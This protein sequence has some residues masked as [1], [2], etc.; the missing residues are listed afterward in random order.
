VTSA[1]NPRLVVIGAGS[2]GVTVGAAIAWAGRADVAFATRG[3]SAELHLAVGDSPARRLDVEIMNDPGRDYHPAD[4]VLV[5]TKSHQVQGAA[6]WLGTLC[7]DTTSVV[8]LQ[9]GVEHVACIQPYVGSARVIPAI[10]WLTA[11]AQAP[12]QIRASL[13]DSRVCVPDDEGGRAFARLLTG[14]LVKAQVRPDFRAE[15]WRK[16]SIN[17][18]LGLTAM[19]LL[20]TSV[21]RAAPMHGLAYRLA[22]E[23]LTVARAEGAELG[24][25]T[26]DA[27]MATVTALP[28]GHVSSIL[29]DR[30]AGRPLEWQ[31]RNGVIGRFGA[32][33]GI[34]TPVSDVV[35]GVLAGASLAAE[36]RAESCTDGGNA[37]RLSAKECK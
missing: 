17:A 26:A 21:L 33:H 5:A 35:A 24:D 6:G 36:L 8:A 15:A 13:R 1:G 28:D 27:V 23:C 30:R 37:F 16:L 9:N 20:E 4:W 29:R 34:P 10:V 32:R 14:T 19:A 18:V 3:A 11:V 2:V 12:G 22:D 31:A 25:W 7:T